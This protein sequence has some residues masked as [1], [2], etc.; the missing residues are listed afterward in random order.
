MQGIHIGLNLCTIWYLYTTTVNIQ[1]ASLGCNP[2]IFMCTLA[3]VLFLNIIS[4]AQEYI[5]L[6]NA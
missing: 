2:V 1:F 5:L 6:I 4:I 3:H